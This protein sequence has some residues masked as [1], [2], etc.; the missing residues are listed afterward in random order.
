MDMTKVF[1]S[2]GMKLDKLYENVVKKYIDVLNVKYTDNIIV[3]YIKYIVYIL[4]N[5]SKPSLNSI[6]SYIKYNKYN[7][8][9]IVNMI[10]LIILYQLK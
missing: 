8:R 7:M 3:S 2:N 9:D 10:D 6:K 4:N 1:N 5:M